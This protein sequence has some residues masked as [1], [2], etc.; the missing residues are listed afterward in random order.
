MGKRAYGQNDTKLKPKKARSLNLAR[1]RVS[2]SV[3]VVSLSDRRETQRNMIR[4]TKTSPHIADS[5]DRC[6]L[7]CVR[8]G[9]RDGAQRRR[10]VISELRYIIR[11]R[12]PIDAPFS[13]ALLR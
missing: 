4:Y 9:K 11:L 1:S 2:S 10:R 5:R 6:V 7:L 3:F 12:A 8:Y 13:K